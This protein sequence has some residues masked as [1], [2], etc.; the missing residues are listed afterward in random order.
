MDST[1]TS[2]RSAATGIHA[3]GRSPRARRRRTGRLI[4]PGS[5]CR[6]QAACAREARPAYESEAD[7]AVP[8]VRT[9]PASRPATPRDQVVAVVG[10]DPQ[11]GD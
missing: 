4:T 6:L 7:P 1:N 2:R 11:G 3:G 10:S 5:R 9:G 8:P